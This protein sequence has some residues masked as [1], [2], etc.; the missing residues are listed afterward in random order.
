MVWNGGEDED[1]EWE[2]DGNGKWMGMG[3]GF[4]SLQRR[5]G[6]AIK[7]KFP[8]RKGRGRGG[9]SH[10]MYQNAFRNVT[11]KRPPPSAPLRWLRSILLMAQP[12][13]LFQEGNPSSISH[14]PFRILHFPFLISHVSLLISLSLSHSPFAFPDPLSR[15]RV[16]SAR[17]GADARG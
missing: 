15:P 10:T 2:M 5:G 14:S 17:R 8:F 7:K 11:C 6:R 9:R 4:P 1:E 13:L 12:P 16:T 3:N